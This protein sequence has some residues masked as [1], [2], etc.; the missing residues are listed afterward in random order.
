VVTC[1]D[2]QLWQQ[3]LQKYFGLDWWRCL[4]KP[5]GK[6]FPLTDGWFMNTPQIECG[7]MIQPDGNISNMSHHAHKLNNMRPQDK[8]QKQHLSNHNY[9]V[10]SSP[11]GAN[12]YCCLDMQQSTTHQKG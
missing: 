9:F 5:L 6:W 10:Q 3:A 12:S 4:S 11:D 2:W 7:G 8:P 1:T